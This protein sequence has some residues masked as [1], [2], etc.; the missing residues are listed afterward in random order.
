M[1]NT[2]ECCSA[3]NVDTIE[4]VKIQKRVSPPETQKDLNY[5]ATEENKT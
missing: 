5:E 1:G 4:E 3:E 2:F